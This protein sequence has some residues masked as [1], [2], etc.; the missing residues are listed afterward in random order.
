M[1]QRNLGFG[2]IR[3]GNRRDISTQSID[4]YRG[5]VCQAP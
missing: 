4:V 5:K 3:F 1:L 2:E